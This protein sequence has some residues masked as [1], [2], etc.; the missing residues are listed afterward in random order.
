[1]LAIVDL[2]APIAVPDGNAILIAQAFD[3]QMAL[4]AGIL[5]GCNFLA[6]VQTQN[7]PG[8]DVVVVT[9][10][11]DD[12]KEYLSTD[13]RRTEPSKSGYFEQR[14]Y[15]KQDQSHLFTSW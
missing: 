6:A 2:G 15:T 9:V 5:S 12:N 3:T 11:A 10:F 1:V 13:L 4:G 8:R 7:E 14:Y